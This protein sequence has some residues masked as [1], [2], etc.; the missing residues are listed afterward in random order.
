MNF[1]KMAGLALAAALLAPGAAGAA[2][3]PA[4]FTACKACHKV[5]A[6]KNGIG[7]SLFAVFG[8]KAGTAEGFA[9]YSDALKASGTVWDDE[10]LTAWITNPKAVIP[11]TKM[12]FPGI[13]KPEDVKAVVDYLKT[14]K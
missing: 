5:E 1:T 13:K 9:L 3:A 14:L 7:P 12:M 4:A 2:D 10:K 8:R 11:T 6:G